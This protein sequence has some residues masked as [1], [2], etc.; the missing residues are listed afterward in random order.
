MS[1]ITTREGSYQGK[2]ILVVRSY[3]EGKFVGTQIQEQ[4]KCNCPGEVTW[5]AN[6]WT[7][8]S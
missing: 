7:G 1:P 5:S 6:L 8:N 2:R 3:G 4:G